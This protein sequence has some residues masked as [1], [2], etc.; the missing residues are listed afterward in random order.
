MVLGVRKLP[1]R[2]IGE[3]VVSENSD[4]RKLTKSHSFKYLWQVLPFTY[5]YSVFLA[6]QMRTSG[7]GGGFENA[8]TPGQGEG[9]MKI[10]DFGGQFTRSYRS[11]TGAQLSG[12]PTTSHQWVIIDWC[13]VVVFSLWLIGFPRV[14]T[15]FPTVPGLNWCAVVGRPIRP[16][17]LAHTNKPYLYHHSDFL[18]SKKMSKSAQYKLVFNMIIVASLATVHR[19]ECFEAGSNI[20]S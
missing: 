17:H 15:P 10:R 2:G 20:L 6:L 13:S 12:Q 1:D 7:G 18:L 8:D 4:V 19:W 16:I 3:G 9:G 11:L 14:P 5:F